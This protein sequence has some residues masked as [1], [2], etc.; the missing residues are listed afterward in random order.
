ME[1]VISFFEKV[2]RGIFLS[3][4]YIG[5]CFLA[6][7]IS[8]Y[9][10]WESKITCGIWFSIT[11]CVLIACYEADSLSSKVFSIITGIIGIIELVCFYNK[12]FPLW[13]YILSNSLICLTIITTQFDD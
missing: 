12:D 5:F 3:F 11:V 8:K 9:F 4:I 10:G 6:I 2:I 1:N 13:T 7:Y